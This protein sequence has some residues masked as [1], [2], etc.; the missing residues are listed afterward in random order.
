MI[1]VKMIMIF[2]WSILFLIAAP[3]AN[4]PILIIYFLLLRLD[5]ARATSTNTNFIKLFGR[6]MHLSRVPGYNEAFCYLSSYPSLYPLVY[7]ILRVL[8]PVTTINDIQEWSLASREMVMASTDRELNPDAVMGIF[9]LKTIFVLDGF[10]FLS[11]FLTV[12]IFPLC[13]LLLN[14]FVYFRMFE[15]CILLFIIWGLLSVAFLTTNLFI[16]YLS[17]EALP[18]PMFL[19]IG[20]RGTKRRKIHANYYFFMYTLFGSLFLLIGLCIIYIHTG[21]FEYAIILREIRDPSFMTNSRLVQ[22]FDFPWMNKMLSMQA[23]KEII[24]W[25]LFFIPF[26]IKIPL[27]PF[28]LWLP[29]AHAEAPTLGSVILA[30]LLPKLG[31]YGLLKYVIF[32]FPTASFTFAPYVYSLTFFGVWHSTMMVLVLSDLKKIVA[33]SSIA[34]MNFAVAAL[35]S[36]TYYGILGS[37]FLMFIHGLVSAGLFLCVGVLY[38]RYETRNIHYYGGLVEYTPMFSVHFFLFNLANIAFPG[39]G[40]FVGEFLCILGLAEISNYNIIFLFLAISWTIIATG[41]SI[42]TFARINHGT[43]K[44]QFIT[45][46]YEIDFMEHFVCSHSILMI[47][48]AGLVPSFF[49]IHIEA[50]LSESFQGLPTDITSNLNESSYRDGN[51]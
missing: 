12:F 47:L 48:Y 37:L 14:E 6:K 45:N 21:S 42:F 3:F 35:F 43:P 24:L 49:T 16:F 15:H 44:F 10:S 46:F 50:M 29:E 41:Y 23:K 22:V 19:L 9:E 39:T 7:F 4:I 11:I 51:N 25:F 13:F 32:L 26:A 27:F 18:I 34:H 20:L 8:L 31:G 40:N 17:F 5:Q 33:Y 2:N 1:L 36:P 28:H 30:S 38:K